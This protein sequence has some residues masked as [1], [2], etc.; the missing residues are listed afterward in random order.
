MRQKI[1]AEPSDPSPAGSGL[2]MR[3]LESDKVFNFETT[4]NS[5]NVTSSRVSVSAGLQGDFPWDEKD[6]RYLAITVAGVS[7]VLLYLYLR[8]NGREISWKDF[9]HRYVGRG[10]VRRTFLLS[11]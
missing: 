1:R 5:S 10:I 2:I 4:G 7:S 3:T 9:V 8:D 6:F 11:Y